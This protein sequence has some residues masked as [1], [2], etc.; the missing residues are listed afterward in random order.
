MY[1][2]IYNCISA[3]CSECVMSAGSDVA[4]LTRNRMR[5]E[6][7]QLHVGVTN[8]SN[9]SSFENRQDLNY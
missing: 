8:L 7:L 6:N 9:E 4:R 2:Y 1:I 5:R 3:K